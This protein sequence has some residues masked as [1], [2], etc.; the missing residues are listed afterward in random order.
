MEESRQRVWNQAPG[1][2]SQASE[3][4][5]SERGLVG[6]SYMQGEEYE[7]IEVG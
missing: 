6:S 3:S 2:F 5:W 7:R 4:Q 1:V